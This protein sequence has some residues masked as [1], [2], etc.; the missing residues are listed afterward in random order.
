MKAKEEALGELP[1][2]LIGF[3]RETR[4]KNGQ[5]TPGQKRSFPK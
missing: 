2:L 5:L 1:H 4:Y 3:P